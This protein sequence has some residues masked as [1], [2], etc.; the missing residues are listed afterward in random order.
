M[1]Y[2]VLILALILILVLVIFLVLIILFV[3]GAALRAFGGGKKDDLVLADPT[4]PRF[5]YWEGGL[6]PL[7]SSIKS[8]ITDFWLLSWPGKIRCAPPAP[9]EDCVDLDPDSTKMV[10]IYSWYLTVN[11]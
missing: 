2:I 3:L 11:S 1:F 5:V 7:P 6:F 10:G 8:I 9:L 4:L